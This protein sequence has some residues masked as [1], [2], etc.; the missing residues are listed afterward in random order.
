VTADI[1]AR[2]GRGWASGAELVYRPIATELIAMAP[3]PL[4]GRVVLDA[5]AGTGA[6]SAVLAARHARPLAMDISPG[7]LAWNTA[8]GA[9]RAAADIRALPLATAS[10]DDTDGQRTP[11]RMISHEAL[12]N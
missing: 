10:V 12:T 1:Y 11:I 5:G 3:H 2:A 7:M 4:A 9:A 8:A 6:A